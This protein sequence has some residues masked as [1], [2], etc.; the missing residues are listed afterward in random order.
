LGEQ[1][2]DTGHPLLHGAAMRVPCSCD[3]CPWAVEH[4]K[5]VVASYGLIITAFAFVGARGRPCRLQDRWL[6]SIYEKTAA[7]LRQRSLG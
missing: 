2:R 5:T 1:R 3:R 7:L 6:A 4:R